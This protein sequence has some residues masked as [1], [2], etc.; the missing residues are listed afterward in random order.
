MDAMEVDGPEM[1]AM[2][3]EDLMSKLPSL[4]SLGETAK[5][6]PIRDIS[7]ISYHEMS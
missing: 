2:Q 5:D 4:R 7:D 3:L 6:G 1:D